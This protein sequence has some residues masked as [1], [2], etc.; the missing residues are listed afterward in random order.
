MLRS[1]WELL[2]G[3]QINPS[4]YDN[5]ASSRML[6]IQHKYISKPSDQ[7]ILHLHGEGSI[8]EL[9]MLMWKFSLSLS[10]LEEKKKGGGELEWES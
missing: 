5:Y 2:N 4:R 1:G 10:V 6:V 9:Y 7:K 3:L 8:I